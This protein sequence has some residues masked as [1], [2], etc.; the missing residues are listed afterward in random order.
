MYIK[1]TIIRNF[2]YSYLKWC[3]T[4][5]F[6]IRYSKP[7]F[8]FVTEIIFRKSRNTNIIPSK[9][10]YHPIYLNENDV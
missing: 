2:C 10:M 8:T 7:T 6:R 1:M 9:K 5:T 4:K 3:G